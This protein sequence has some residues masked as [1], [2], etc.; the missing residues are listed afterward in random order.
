MALDLRRS[1]DPRE[2][3]EDGGAEG[4]ATLAFADLAVDVAV[5]EDPFGVR[6]EARIETAKGVENQLDRIGV[7][8][9]L[10][11]GRQRCVDILA[12]ELVGETISEAGL[13][14]AA[15][16]LLAIKNF[17]PKIKENDEQYE[18]KVKLNY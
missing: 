7:G 16:N 6:R 13:V 3:G 14:D 10:V 12:T 5:T 9:P 8:D 4:A 18:I 11:G 1:Q 15:G 2:G 17:A